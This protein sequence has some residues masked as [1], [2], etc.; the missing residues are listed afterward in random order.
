MLLHRKFVFEKRRK[1]IHS[2]RVQSL[3]EGESSSGDFVL[4]WMEAARRT[5]C[6]HAL[7]YAIDKGRELN[8]PVVVLYGLKGQC[9]AENERHYVFLLEGLLE[10]EVALQQRGIAFVVYLQ[11][12]ERAAAKIGKR[13]AFIVT[14]RGY[15]REQIAWR[16]FLAA[17]ISCP[18]EQVETEL[19]VPV[20]LVSSKEEYSAATFR[21]RIRSHMESFLVPLQ[22]RE[23]QE[24]SLDLGLESLDLEHWE[25]LLP[26]LKMDRSVKRQS[27][28][29]GGES[30]AHTLLN[31]FIR[32]KLPYYASERNDPSKGISSGLSPYLHF[33]QISP[34]EVAL[35]I[36]RSDASKEAK[37][38]FIEELVVRREL[39]HNFVYYNKRY[40]EFD[41]L[42]SWAMRTL[43]DHSEDERP[44]VYELSE[45]EKAQTH[46]VYWNA[47][48]KEILLTGTMANYMR[49]YWGKKILEWSDT[50]ELAFERALYLNNKYG[51]DG[52]DPNSFAGVAWCFGKHDRPWQERAIFGK[53]RYMN[54]SGLK[55]KFAIKAYVDGIKNLSRGLSLL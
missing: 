37:D 48:Q 22:P 36:R 23:V 5:K 20:E 6:N 12:P 42:P 47:A 34:L 29:I 8:L 19:L 54:E 27:Q 53:V 18:V 43:S 33:G 52:W 35:E 40:D 46:D 30:H 14:D 3:N 24:S 4:Y 9:C 41:C 1:M 10:T 39:A 51:L 31:S 17:N 50:P 25:S 15:L 55:R 21:R 45:L 49:M 7:E 38:A 26:D 16:Q 2:E 44:Y 13:A 28:W 11:P 32:E